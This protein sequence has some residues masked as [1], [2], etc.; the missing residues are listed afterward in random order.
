MA[1]LS[2]VPSMHPTE[3]DTAVLEDGTN[4]AINLIAERTRKEIHPKAV[5]ERISRKRKKNDQSALP[6][7]Q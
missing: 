3:D 6:K 5:M 7:S 1:L 4:G 2:K